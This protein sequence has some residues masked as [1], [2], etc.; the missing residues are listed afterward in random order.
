M[1]SKVFYQPSTGWITI[2]ISPYHAWQGYISDVPVEFIGFIFE[3]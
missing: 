2:H 3:L 1:E